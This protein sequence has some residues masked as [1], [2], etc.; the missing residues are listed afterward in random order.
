M[1]GEVSVLQLQSM[2]DVCMCVLVGVWKMWKRGKVP[3]LQRRLY[4][5]NKLINLLPVG[6]QTTVQYIQQS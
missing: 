1:R 4:Q 2:C 6:F 3:V 5:L